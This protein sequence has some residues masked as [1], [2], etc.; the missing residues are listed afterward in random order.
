M[1]DIPAVCD[2]CGAV[3]PSG[4]G[5]DGGS[6]I[7]LGNNKS[8]PCPNCN[9]MGSVLDGTFRLASGALEVLTAPQRTVEEL[10]RLSQVLNK[11]KEQRI[12]PEEFKSEVENELPQ[13][14]GLLDYLP[15]NRSERINAFYFFISTLLTIISIILSNQ[16][17]GG[18]QIEINNNIEVNQVINNIYIQNE[19]PNEK[20]GR[21][22]P[23]YC[24]S[25]IKYKKCHGK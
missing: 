13:F 23:C 2:D 14:S 15:K 17:G 7:T 6:I 3:F 5:G 22:E 19:L 9:G 20:I 10:K 21:N 24:G 11:A 4:I 25:G 16:N 18:D 8:G 1:V 12:T